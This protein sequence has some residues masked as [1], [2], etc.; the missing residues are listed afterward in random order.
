MNISIDPSSGFCFG[1]EKAI[2]KAESELTS[3]QPLYCLG[4]I[5]HNPVEV[6]R[7]QNLG[8]VFI[9]HEQ[10][11][12]LRNCKVLLRAHG[13]PPET[14]QI[15]TDNNIVLIDATCPIVSRL[16]KVIRTT[17]EELNHAEEQIVIF[18]KHGHAEV[19]G[20]I[21]QVGGMVN[22]VEST[23]D[24]DKLDF[25]RRIH[26]FSQ[27]TMGAEDYVTIQQEILQKFSQF[28]I[29]SDNLIVKPSVC[30]QV[31]NR[32]SSV[33]AFARKHDVILFASGTSSSNGKYLFELCKEVN[34]NT[35][36]ISSIKDLDFSLVQ[37]KKNIG[38]TGATSTPRWFMEQIQFELQ[39]YTD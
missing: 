15:A 10:F 32:A 6:E 9:D 8:L 5:V 37:D 11:K 2:R 33:I 31:S 1:V 26:L 19:V 4:E 29:S 3:N 22:V 25:T 20:L 12:K 7:L 36:F 38:I 18:G 17:F 21:G 28:G 13:E 34:S 30:K 24:I 14:Y 35:H 27:T 39:K 16:Q 23:C